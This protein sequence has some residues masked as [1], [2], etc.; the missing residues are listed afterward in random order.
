MLVSKCVVPSRLGLDW[1]HCR[2]AV[3]LNL[4]PVQLYCAQY[5]ALSV[6]QFD[7]QELA[8]FSHHENRW[9][10]LKASAFFV[11]YAK[12]FCYSFVTILSLILNQLV[13]ER[14]FKHITAFL[15]PLFNLSFSDGFLWLFVEILWNLF[16]N[17]L[18]EYV[19]IHGTTH[20]LIYAVHLSS[21]LCR[22]AAPTHDVSISIFQC[23]Y[24]LFVTLFFFLFFLLLCP[25]LEKVF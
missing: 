7:E 10:S 11:L 15:F 16:F 1:V 24:V 20:L 2:D 8:S 9:A 5:S 19:T 4:L 3:C 23:E 14:D 17:V 6:P 18:T 25:L 22:K 13:H 21:P 12:F